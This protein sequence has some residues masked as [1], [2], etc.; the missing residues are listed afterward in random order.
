MG[1]NLSSQLGRV[2]DASLDNVG[3]ALQPKLFPLLGP[4]LVGH[5]ALLGGHYS[6]IRM[7]KL[8]V[9]IC[10]LHAEMGNAD[11][12]IVVVGL[13]WP[14]QMNWIGPMIV[15]QGELDHWLGP[16]A[17]GQQMRLPID[18][19]NGKSGLNEFELNKMT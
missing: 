19:L 2:L 10:V 7:P 14:R 18:F 15:A 4:F 17:R 11:F 6:K 13:D 12:G 3:L 16:K 5:D 8:K 9:N 1:P